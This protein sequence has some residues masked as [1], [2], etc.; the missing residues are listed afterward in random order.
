MA[1]FLRR[2]KAESGCGI[3]GMQ[4]CWSCERSDLRAVLAAVDAAA[5][6]GSG[7]DAGS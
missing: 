1:A 4:D 3:L 2:F 6:S 7:S 5:R